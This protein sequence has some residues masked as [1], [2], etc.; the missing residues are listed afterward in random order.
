MIKLTTNHG[1][2]GIELDADKA[3]KS[4]ANFL[5][6]VEAGH[7]DNTI[8]HRVIDGFMIQG[9]GFEPGMNQ[10]PV[11]EPIEERS[12]ERPAQRALHGRHGANLDPHSATAQ[13]FINVGDNDFLDN[14]KCQDGWGYC[15][16]RPRRRRPGR[17][18]QD[19]GSEDRQQGL[20]P[21][22]AAEDVIIERAEKPEVAAVS[23]PDLA[24]TA[25]FVSDLHLRAERPDLLRR[26]ATFLADTAAANVESL[27]ILG[28]LF[29]YWIGDDDLPTRSTPTSAT[30][31]AARR[32]WVTR[33][34][35]RRQSRLSDRP[36]LCRRGAHDCCSTK[37]TKS[38]PAVR[39]L[40][41]CM[42]IRSAP[43]TCPTRSSAAWC[44]PR[45][46]TALS[47]PPLPERRAEV[48]TCADAAPKPCR[49]DG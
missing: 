2:I 33:L 8:F 7:Y 30:C 3:P 48:E 22:R 34:F 23:M 19:Q 18:G 5:A 6:Y 12:E 10:K 4:A 47:G 42:A 14:D 27:F 9:G 32:T 1:V 25:R 39:R 11:R 45:I 40:C 44:A 16:F 15:V 35:H 49:Q 36:A 13:F 21:E 43:T 29:E 46:G 24:G 41:C 37:P 28:D 38:A 26:F 20:P 17:G 31:C